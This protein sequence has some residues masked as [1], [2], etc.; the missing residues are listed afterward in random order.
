MPGSLLWATPHHLLSP[1]RYLVLGI[2][3]SRRT[4]DL[5]TPD[6]APW[7]GSSVGRSSTS[8]GPLRSH[9]CRPRGVHRPVGTR[10]PCTGPGNNVGQ[11]NTENSPRDAANIH[12]GF[13][14]PV[15]GT[16]FGGRKLSKSEG[17]RTS[18]SWSA[19]YTGKSPTVQHLAVDSRAGL[20]PSGT[21]NRLRPHEDC[22]GKTAARRLY[23]TLIPF[24][25]SPGGLELRWEECYGAISEV[26]PTVLY[27][28]LI[29]VIS[30]LYSVLL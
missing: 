8:H 7:F 12:A 6:E 30:A 10:R 16:Q 4:P 29:I 18:G 2:K 24:F 14:L 5:S 3:R 19:P 13:A 1:F 22:G 11:G 20:R 17:A 15:P 23:R 27:H 21:S 9:A 25:T 28:D 26:V